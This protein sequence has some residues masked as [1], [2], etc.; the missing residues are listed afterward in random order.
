AIVKSINLYKKHIKAQANQPGGIIEI[1]KPLHLS[2]LQ[3]ICPHCQKRTRVAY[4]TDKSA[5][6]FRICRKC[7]AIIDKLNK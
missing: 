6:K 5:K 7:K 2:K 3:L 4:Q 1:E